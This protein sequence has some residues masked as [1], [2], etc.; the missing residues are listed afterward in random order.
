VQFVNELPG[1]PHF[2]YSD[3][4]QLMRVMNNLIRNAMQAI[5]AEREGMIL[6]KLFATENEYCIEVKDNGNGIAPEIQEKIFRP[7]FTTKQSGMGLGLA[8]VKSIIE[9]SKGTISFETIEGIGSSFFVTLP[10]F[11]DSNPT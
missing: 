2:V 10:R 4:E 9:S 8:L 1:G 7:N 11:K 3:K 6:L 5:P